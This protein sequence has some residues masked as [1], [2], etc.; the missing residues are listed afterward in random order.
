[1]VEHILNQTR[2]LATLRKYH[3][4]SHDVAKTTMYCMKNVTSMSRKSVHPTV[5]L[6]SHIKWVLWCPTPCEMS[7]TLHLPGAHRSCIAPEHCSPISSATGN[8]TRR[9]GTAIRSRSLDRSR[10]TRP[11]RQ[12]PGVTTCRIAVARR[13]RLRD[14]CAVSV[15]IPKA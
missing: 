6:A 14:G 15:T 7:T 12:S 10:T 9:S 11:A 13:P 1:M 8:T 3:F 5:V 2:N 4:S